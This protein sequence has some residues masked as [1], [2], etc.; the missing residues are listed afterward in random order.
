MA[1]NGLANKFYANDGS[2]TIEAY[3]GPYANLQA[4][5]DSL[6][7]AFRV[8]GRR[9]GIKT[10]NNIQDYVLN[11]FDDQDSSVRSSLTTSSFSSAGG[12]SVGGS[13][14]APIVDPAGLPIPPSDVGVFL[15]NNYSA[16]PINTKVYDTVNGLSYT[17]IGAS[18]WTQQA[19]V[20]PSTVIDPEGVIQGIS[21]I[22][23]K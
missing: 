2:P 11:G 10:G 14:L 6:P 21:L 20:S 5:L 3:Y 19:S 4:A 8:V 17:K 23:I 7:A 22:S 12:S 18:T 13:E 9:V 15:N 16:N 1:N